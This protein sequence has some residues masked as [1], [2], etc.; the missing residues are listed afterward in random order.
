VVR[1]SPTRRTSASKVASLIFVTGRS[2]IATGLSL[3]R[4]QKGARQQCRRHCERSEAIQR[5]RTL[6][7]ASSLCSSQ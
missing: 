7:I 5:E 3:I 4:S 6:W 1:V 2:S